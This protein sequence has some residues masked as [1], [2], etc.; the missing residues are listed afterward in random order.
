MMLSAYAH[1]IGAGLVDEDA[2]RVRHFSHAQQSPTQGGSMSRLIFSRRAIQQ[3]LDNLSTVVDPGAHGKLV[4]KLNSLNRERL[5]TVWEVAVLSAIASFTS[6]TH[7]AALPSGK[8]PV[9]R[10][11]S[12]ST[13]LNS[14]WWVT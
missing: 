8:R 13:G 7:E 2:K 3:A 1:S 6:L 5:S 14:R 9:S 10:R 11:G 12:A 4:T